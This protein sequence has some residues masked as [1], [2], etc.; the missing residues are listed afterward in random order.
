MLD[1]NFYLPIRIVIKEGNIENAESLLKE[2]IAQIGLGENDVTVVKGKS[3]LVIDFGE[4][5]CGGVRILMHYINNGKP[6]RRDERSCPARFFF[7]YSAVIGR[8]L[9]TNGFSFRM[10]G[11]F[12]RRVQNKKCYSRK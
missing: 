11:V 9:W 3:R 7:G 1:K 6:I 8:T 5:L 4:E 10:F 12:G 2:K